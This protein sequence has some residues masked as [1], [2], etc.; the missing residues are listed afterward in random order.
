MRPMYFSHY[1][2][3][4]TIM[5]GVGLS[6]CGQT[7]TTQTSEKDPLSSWEKLKCMGKMNAMKLGLQYLGINSP[8]T[9]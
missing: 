8:K 7:S 4:Q 3:A 5:Y 9:K 6:E 1:K 2:D